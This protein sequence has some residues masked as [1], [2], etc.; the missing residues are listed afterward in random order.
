MRKRH[1]I[2]VVE[3]DFDAREMIVD[4]LLNAGYAV[5]KAV[6]GTEAI[7]MAA[8]WPPD[9]LLSD[10]RLPGINGVELTRRLHTFAPDLPVVLTTSLEETYDICT[11]APDYGAVACLRKP[12]NIAD[13]LWTVDRALT[14][15]PALRR[16]S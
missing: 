14:E 2:L 3:D 11:S 15:R 10:L 1:R 9:L 7:F 12:M 8:R 4:A 13:L 6:D 5:A 16:A